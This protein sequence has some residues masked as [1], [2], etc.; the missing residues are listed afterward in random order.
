MKTKNLIV[1]ACM[2]I[3]SSLTSQNGIPQS[4]STLG[5]K[6][7]INV[8]FGTSAPLMHHLPGSVNASFD[9]RFTP[10]WH[11]N[12]GVQAM[13]YIP[14][15]LPKNESPNMFNMFPHNIIT[16]KHLMFGKDLY[17]KNK[18]I[19]IL[20][21]PS[22]IKF[23]HNNPTP[24]SFNALVSG[25]N[26]FWKPSYYYGVGFFTQAT[27][28]LA[29]SRRTDLQLQVSADL[30]EYKPYVGVGFLVGFGKIKK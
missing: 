17:Y 10:S 22:L 29:R 5:S 9:Y 20:A 18:I 2:S 3:C 30:N 16:S 4:Q 13:W 19:T 8:G 14:E 28:S 25:G 7:K 26:Y 12:L 1:V 21:G 11:V 23:S 15:Y 27:T 24:R 6:W